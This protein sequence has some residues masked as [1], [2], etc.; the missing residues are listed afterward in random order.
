MLEKAK[1]DGKEE[2]QLAMVYSM[3]E[4]GYKDDDI[5]AVVWGSV[6]KGAEIRNGKTV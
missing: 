5:S 4:L 6:E 3:I 1:A 2:Y